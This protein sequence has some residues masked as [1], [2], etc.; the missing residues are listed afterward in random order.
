MNGTPKK[1]DS[2]EISSDQ[3]R[4]ELI[5]IKERLGAIETIESISNRAV[6]DAYVRTHI[7][8]E[9][10]KLVMRECSEPRT[11]DHLMTKLQFASRQA[12]DHHLNPLREADL[13]RQHFDDDG[14]QTFEW[15]NLFRRLPKKA[16]KDI[17]GSG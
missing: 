2:V 3:L 9:K 4:A 8:T 13:L 6:V 12:L 11:R 1:R 14:T 7:T 15:S 17:L 16:L 10:A 5:G